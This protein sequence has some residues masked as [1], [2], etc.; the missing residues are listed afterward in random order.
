MTA[1]RD[2]SVMQTFI[3]NCEGWPF[4]FPDFSDNSLC[5]SCHM[6]YLFPQASHS[7]SSLS[8][9]N[10]SVFVMATPAKPSAYLAPLR[11][12]PDLSLVPKVLQ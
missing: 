2:T 11:A 1:A 12:P 10:P 9:L 3:E 5:S 6:K 4:F 8:L 7:S